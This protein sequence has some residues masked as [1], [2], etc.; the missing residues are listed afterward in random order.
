MVLFLIGGPGKRVL[1]HVAREPR[2][3]HVTALTLHR[4]MGVLTVTV[5]QLSLKTAMNYCVRVG[6]NFTFVCVL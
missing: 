2:L 5:K 3:A 4:H 1:L 6:E